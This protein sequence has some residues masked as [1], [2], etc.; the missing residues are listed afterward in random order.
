MATLT[1]L[2]KQNKTLTLRAA[3]GA[4]FQAMSLGAAVKLGSSIWFVDKQ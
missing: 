4:A 2:Q 3:G 1:S